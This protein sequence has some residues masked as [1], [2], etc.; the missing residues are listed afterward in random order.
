MAVSNL[1]TNLQT[2][3]KGHDLSVVSS[4][5]DGGLFKS[6]RRGPYL[7]TW[8]ATP[9]PVYDDS[10]EYYLFEQALA[11][12]GYG[13]YVLN[14]EMPSHE[15]KNRGTWAGTPTLVSTTP[16][17]F[18][19]HLSGFTSNVTNIVKMG[20]WVQ[21]P[22]LSTKVYQVVTDSSSDGSGELIIVIN[23]PVI[24]NVAVAN[25]SV[26]TGK[27]VTFKFALTNFSDAEKTPVSNTKNLAQFGAFTLSEVL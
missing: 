24:K 21:F 5:S 16:S 14:T 17:G 7:Y 23:T 2:L 20:D 10:D 8:R 9:G 13:S 25:T 12:A 27:D 18:N 15:V 26:K 6:I 4:K 19:I 3:E 1:L 22:G 11:G